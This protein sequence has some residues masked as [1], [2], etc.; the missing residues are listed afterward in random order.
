MKLLRS[1]PLLFS[2]AFVVAAD[3]GPAASIELFNG[4]DLSN[5]YTFLKG[6]GRDVDPRRVFTVRDGVLVIS[7]EEWGCITTNEE[8]RDYHLIV[9]Y[10]W[11]DATHGERADRARDS[12]VLVHSTGADGA[13]SGTWMH[14]IECQIIEGGTGDLLV[15]GDGSETFSLTAPV[16]AEK[17]DTSYVFDLNGAPAT[18]NG[19]RINWWG[20][21]PEWTDTKGFRGTRD[22]ERPV[23]E[24]NRLECVVAGRTI[25]VYLN[26]VLVNQCVDVMPRKGRI[27]IQSEGAEIRLRRVTLTP[28]AK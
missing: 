15:V 18:I 11:G 8:Y 14:S 20:R 4:K 19:G 16:A 9:E 6:R 10:A 7:G 1:S 27:Q 24:W 2:V 23:G 26:G 17:Q 3:P 5:F 21:S 22:L 28:F 12:G 13:Y 25:T